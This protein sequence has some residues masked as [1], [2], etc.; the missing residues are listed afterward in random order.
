MS[1]FL[2]KFPKGQCLLPPSPEFQESVRSFVLKSDA[3]C[4]LI[5]ILGVCL[6]TWILMYMQAIHQCLFKTGC[7]SYSK[8]VRVCSKVEG[9]GPSESHPSAWLSHCCPLWISNY[10]AGTIARL[11]CPFLR[12]LHARTSPNQNNSVLRGYHLVLPAWSWLQ[13]QRA[14]CGEVIPSNSER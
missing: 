7:S 2:S 13:Q 11:G 1:K 14:L 3:W 10:L 8:A 6:V 12:V 9:K 5:L 4:C